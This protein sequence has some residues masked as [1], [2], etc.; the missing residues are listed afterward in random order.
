MSLSAQLE[1]RH[2]NPGASFLEDV[3][4]ADSNTIMV[5]GSN[6]YGTTLNGGRHWNG[7]KLVSVAVAGDTRTGADW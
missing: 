5:T 2:W 4:V 7:L 1:T 3:I 6:Y